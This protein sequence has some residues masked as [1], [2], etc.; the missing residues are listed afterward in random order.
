MAVTLSINVS[1]IDAAMA[2]FNVIKVKR[3][4]AGIGGP[5]TDITALTPQ[6]ATLAPPLPSPYNVVS[7]TLQIVRDS[8]PQVD[9]VFTGVDPLSAAQ[10]V[11]QFNTALGATVAAEVLGELVLTSTLVGTASKLKIVNGAAATEFGWAAN[12]KDIGEEAHIQLV[13][14][15]TIYSFTDNDGEASYYY[16]AQFLNTSNNLTSADSSPFQGDAGTLVNASNLAVATVDLI[17]GRGTA[18]QDQEI[19]FYGVNEVFDV[20]TYQIVLTRKPI[21]IITDTSGHAEVPLV[22]GSRWK[23]V[24]EGTSFVREFVVPTTSPFNLL[25]ILAAAPDPF[26]I[27]EP[28]FPAAPRRTL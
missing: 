28:Q 10:L 3:S 24:F 17:D 21:T 5:Y 2:S 14:G 1:N 20:E 27:A 6:P 12:T 13:A 15:Q 9:I 23:V 8:E 26:T 7:K 16:V 11:P 25:T 22:K 18:L 19:T 4:I